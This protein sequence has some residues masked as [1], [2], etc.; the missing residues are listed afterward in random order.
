VTRFKPGIPPCHD[1]PVVVF[2]PTQDSSD[3]PFLVL[4]CRFR[5]LRSSWDHKSALPAGL[6]QSWCRLVVFC[7]TL[8]KRKG[9]SNLI[10]GC[11]WIEGVGLPG[12]RATT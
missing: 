5:G 7:L 12:G 1:R 9:Y 6:G 8:G 10:V 4:M 11:R 2:A 3:Q